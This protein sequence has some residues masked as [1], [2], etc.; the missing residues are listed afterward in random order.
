[1]TTNLG[2]ESGSCEP[3][4]LRLMASTDKARELARHFDGRKK[5][6]YACSTLDHVNRPPSP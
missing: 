1:M 3:A 6:D 5:F 2:V 4:Q